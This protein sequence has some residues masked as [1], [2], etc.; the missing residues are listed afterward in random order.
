MIMN[1]KTKQF[2]S[3]K[4]RRYW[5]TFSRNPL[6]VVGLFIICTIIFIAIF[7][8]YVS[9]YP[10]AA[11]G[12]FNFSEASLPPSSNH[13]FGTDIMGRD[14][15]TRIFFGFRISLILGLI[16]LFIS[17]PVGVL[18]GL[19]AGYF[20]DTWVDNLIMRIT[21]VFICIG[22]LIMAMAICSL[23]KPGIVS[24]IF[25]VS[26]VWWT[27]YSRL[28]Y[29]S[30]SALKGEFFIQSA[31][32]IGASTFHILFREILP[33]IM[34]SLLTKATL[35]M[36][37][38]I[39]LGSTLSFVGLGAQMPTPDLGTM[40]AEGSRYLPEQ[41]W[42]FVFPATFIVIIILGFNL[43]GDGIHDLVGG[44]EGGQI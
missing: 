1:R 38:V 9:P 12:Y 30:T 22:A 43:L 20:R 29:S 14:V 2:K 40:T 28:A 41:W 35:D 13:W 26:L 31:E 33:N 44:K 7:A 3:D 15:M 23:L 32:V 18:L 11:K 37:W 6:N 24:A 19:I 34:S 25:A 5:Y 42:M 8:P 10:E 39:L 21:D 4:M 27:I 36:G 17:A 16:I